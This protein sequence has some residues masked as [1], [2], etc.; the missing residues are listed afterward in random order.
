MTHLWIR[1]EERPNEK[2]VGVTPNGVKSLLQAGFDVTIERDSTRAISIESYSGAQVAGT[3]DWRSAPKEAIIIGLKELP[4]EITPLHH[5]HIMFGHAF[6]D[7][8]DGQKLLERFQA[9]GGTLY[10][11]EYLT[12]DTG[13]R[14][15]AFGYWAGYAGAAVAIKSWAAAQKGNICQPLQTFASAKDLNADVAL[16]L[17]KKKPSVIIIGAN[18]RVGSG[19]QDFCAALGASVTCWDIEETAHGGPFPEILDHDIFLNCILANK[20]TPVF[21]PK[22]AKIGPRKLMV[23]GDIACDPGSFYSPIKVYDCATSWEKPALRV[24]KDKI[25]DI[26]AI[27]N[28]PSL[29]PRESSEDFAAQLLPHLM[30]LQEIEKGVWGKACAIFNE[31]IS[32]T[33]TAKSQS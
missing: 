22:K 18:G 32:K 12:D 27:D 7:Q 3:G 11:L 24:H 6:K 23:I 26:T 5:R 28:L 8:P 10:D 21:V 19:A 9:G 14:V 31:Y 25:L 33:N 17:G 2:R 13:R 29:L 30:M 1:A 15:A 16:D 4:E 20:N